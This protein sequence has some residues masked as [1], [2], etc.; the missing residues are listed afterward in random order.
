M[1]YSILQ[2]YVKINKDNQIQINWL[3]F[4][5]DCL[6]AQKSS[7]DEELKVYFKVFNFKKQ[8]ILKK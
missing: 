5:R 6:S 3:N 1:I 8:K 4:K 7:L 2:F